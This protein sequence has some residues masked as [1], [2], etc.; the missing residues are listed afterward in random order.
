MKKRSVYRRHRVGRHSYVRFIE[1]PDAKKR[2]GVRLR[3]D[4][5][6]VQAGRWSFLR[7]GQ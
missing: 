7:V 1:G 5:E 2:L 3:G 4:A 6:R